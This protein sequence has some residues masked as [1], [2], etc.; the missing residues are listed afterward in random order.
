[1]LYGLTDRRHR[2]DDSA[3]LLSGCRPGRANCSGVGVGDLT[4]QAGYGLTQLPG[5]A[6]TCPRSRWCSMRRCPPGAMTGWTGQRRRWGGRVRHRVFRLFAGV[7]LDAQ[8][9][10]PARAPRPDLHASPP[11]VNV[12]DASVY[13]TPVGF[14]GRAYPGDSASPSTPRPSTASPASG[15]W[16][17]MWSTSTTPVRT[18]MAARP[19]WRAQRR[20]RV[21]VLARVCPGDRVQ[22][23][24]TGRRAARGAHHPDRPQYLRPASRPALAVNLVF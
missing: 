17:W 8:R 15:C 6:V 5:R 13:G 21:L 11:S 2:G 10:H 3:V 9:A 12:Q 19:Q 4:L 7:F 14:R 16:R 24:R 23:E 20:F 18:C 22:L 1:M